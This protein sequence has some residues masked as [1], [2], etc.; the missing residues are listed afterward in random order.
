MANRPKPFAGAI[1]CALFVAIALV[2]CA[3]DEQTQPEQQQPTQQQATT[4][5]S[6]MQPSSTYMQAALDEA[7]RGIEAGDGG[8]FGSVVVKDGQ[9]VGQ[10]HNRVLAEQDPTCHGEMEA[11]RDA[12]RTLG[13]H[14]L[15]GCEL[16]TTA[17]PCPMCLGAIL[18]SN[19]SAVYYGCTREDSAD[20]GFRNDAFYRQLAGEEQTVSLQEFERDSCLQLF[21]DYEARDAQRY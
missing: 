20:I 7:R 3:A 10:G 11:I 18:W 17:E 9:I 21:E 2:G 8:P 5:D 4:G 14:D 13:T 1:V 6:T 12:C 15:S 16:Y 19:M